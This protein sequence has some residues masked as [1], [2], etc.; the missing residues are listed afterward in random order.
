M[1]KKI[2]GLVLVCAM[3]LSFFGGCAGSKN[4]VIVG[5]TTELTGDFRWP[6]FGGSSAG[7]ADQ[8]ING[9]TTGYSTMETNQD[10]DY[11]WNE[12]VVKS[13]TEEEDADGNY[14]I[15]IEI[16]PGLKFSDGTEVKAANYLAYVLAFS[17]PVAVDAGNPGKVGQTYVGY[18]AYNAYT[19]VEADGAS[20]VFKGIRL[21]DE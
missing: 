18:K 11:V 13:H 20:K 12:T 15:T 17:T 6:G 2:L 7:A 8:D 21:L 3:V 19:G 9:L 14:V 4:T 10:G 5:N 16:N 1:S